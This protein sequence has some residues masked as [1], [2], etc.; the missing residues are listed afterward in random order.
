MSRVR[1]IE[2][3]LEDPISVAVGGT[4][5]DDVADVVLIAPTAKHCVQA[6][7]IKKRCASTMVQQSESSQREASRQKAEEKSE[8]SEGTSSA[9]MTGG[10]LITLLSVAQHADDN[11]FAELF[12]DFSKMLAAGCGTIGGVSLTPS[13][14]DELSFEDAELMFGEYVITFLLASLTQGGDGEK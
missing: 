11:I 4:K 12:S 7:R 13:L 1:E 9:K 8:Q 3:T 14:F 6:G 2:F 5:Q 10:D